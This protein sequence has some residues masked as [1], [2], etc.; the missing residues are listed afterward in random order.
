MYFYKGQNANY[1]VINQNGTPLGG[2]ISEPKGRDNG[3][4][5]TYQTP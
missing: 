5:G 3:S 2:G 4:I 1:E